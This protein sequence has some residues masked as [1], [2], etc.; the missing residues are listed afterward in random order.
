MSK[1]FYGSLQNRIS[2]RSF[3]TVPE[4]GM[5]A[6]ELLYSDRHAYTILEVSKETITATRDV[7]MEDHTVKPLTRTYPKWIMVRQD[8]A[9]LLPGCSIFG[10]Q[11]YEYSNDGD[12]SKA[13]KAF[14]HK[15]SGQYRFESKVWKDG[16]RV[17]SGRTN[18]EMSIIAIGYRNEY[19]DPS[20]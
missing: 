18:M 6:T 7:Y 14:Y 12:I 10:N 16:Q 2:E 4:K 20:F 17:G 8:D 3:C 5:G 11:D 19:Y 9:K 13:Q 1:Q 15:Q